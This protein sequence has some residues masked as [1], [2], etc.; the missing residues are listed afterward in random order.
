MCQTAPQ[1]PQ[2][3]W[4]VNFSHSNHGGL[5]SSLQ[6][7]ITEELYFSFDQEEILRSS[8]RGNFL[9]DIDEEVMKR[10]VITP[11]FER[12]ERVPAVNQSRYTLQK[13]R[14]VCNPHNT[15]FSFIS[16]FLGETHWK[17][18]EFVCTSAQEK[19]VYSPDLIWYVYRFQWD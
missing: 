14:K 4:F 5:A 9:E 1:G 12:K 6:P 13:M 19:V 18:Q 10:S 17:Y 11:D 2:F 7:G 15:K 16:L 8:H 3:Y